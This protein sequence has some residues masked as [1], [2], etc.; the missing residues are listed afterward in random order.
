M[1]DSVVAAEMA[2]LRSPFTLK[3]GKTVPNRFVKAA[4]TEGLADPNTN[5]PNRTHHGLYAA[6]SNGGAGMVITGNVQI[7]ARYL[8]CP[9]NVVIDPTTIM[10]PDEVSTHKQWAAASKA[11]G[12]SLGIVQ[13]SHAG[14]QVPMSVRW[15][16]GVAAG[17]QRLQ[18][19]FQKMLFGK[20]RVLTQ[21]E[22]EALPARWA[23]A[24]ERCKEY[25][26]DGVEIH[27]A[28]G[29]L[30]SSMLNPNSNTRDDK[31]GACAE[32]RRR[33]LIQ[34][35]RAVRQRVGP[36]FIVG[37][38]LNSADFQKGG[39]TEEESL[40]VLKALEKEAVDFVEL[41]GGNYENPSFLTKTP[42]TRATTVVR[43]AFFLEFAARARTHTTLPLIVTGGFRSRTAMAA[44]ITSNGCDFI[45]LGR[46]LIME[47]D[48]PRRILTDP[49]VKGAKVYSYG[50]QVV[51][52]NLP[53]FVAGG[54]ESTWHGI[55]MSNVGEGRGVD[56]HQGIV[57]PLVW[58][59]FY[60]Y[61]MDPKKSSARGRGM[62]LLSGEPAGVVLTGT[63]A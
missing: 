47:P 59:L 26:W 52:K 2:T 63:G 35:V 20:P 9:R 8:E 18:G 44:A 40:E 60:T 61:I 48:L 14:R 55:Q 21:E 49:A 32:N 22:I 16:G 28:H 45:G 3:C 11:N 6:W 39:L 62:R 23:G 15:S 30:L 24:A 43:E 33:L 57:K 4:L 38:K 13:L 19:V 31:Y 51:V 53:T 46:P 42:T 25:G 58:N 56:Y 27:S 29:Y 37:V 41:S 7:D 54:L 5:L 1:A 50:P 10:G 17:P 12:R 34:V 36:D